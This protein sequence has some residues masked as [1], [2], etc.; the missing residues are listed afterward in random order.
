MVVISHPSMRVF[1]T[2]VVLR[3]RHHADRLPVAFAW[4]SS[5]AMHLAVCPGSFA[6]IPARDLP[7]FAVGGQSLKIR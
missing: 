2:P 4:Q 7:R 1:P 6:L 5:P 3:M